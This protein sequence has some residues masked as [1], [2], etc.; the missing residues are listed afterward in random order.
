MAE[1]FLKAIGGKRFEV[2][3]AGFEPKPINPYV[4]EVMKEVGYDLSDNT[5]DSVMHFS[6]KVD[7][8]IMS[9]P[10]AMNLLKMNV[11]FSLVLPGDYTGLF[12]TPKKYREPTLK[13][14]KKCVQSGMISNGRFIFLSKTQHRD[15]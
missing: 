6:K 12:P 10:C 15:S 1:T 14:Y 4:M 9:L 5:S 2:E 8:T 7:Y 13:N 3:S 11:R